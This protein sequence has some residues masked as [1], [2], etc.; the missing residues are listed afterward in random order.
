[1]KLA[2]LNIFKNKID[3]SLSGCG[4]VFHGTSGNITSPG[5]P[6]RYPASTECEW[7]VVARPGFHISMSFIEKF[8]MEISTHCLN[9]FVKACHIKYIFTRSY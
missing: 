4:G 1:M 3:L 6:G 5:S 8:D 7:E 9:D 2:E